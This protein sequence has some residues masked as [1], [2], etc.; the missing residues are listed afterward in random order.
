MKKIYT[1]ACC[2]GLTLTATAQ[3]YGSGMSTGTAEPYVYTN[4]GT[5]VLGI[6]AAEVLSPAQTIPFA[7]NFYGVAVTTYKASDNGYITF[8]AGASTSDPANGSIPNAGGPNDAIYAFWDDL[9]V[10]AG[11][12]SPDEVVSF[13]YGAAP[14]RTHVIQYFSVTPISGTGFMYVA[15]RLHEC[16]DFDIVHNYGNATGMTAT[17]GCEDAT[18]ANGTMVQGPSF[19]YPAL[20]PDGADD[21]VYTFYWD[22]IN[23][24]AAITSSDLTA[25][26]PVGNNTISGQMT[27]NGSQAIT[28]YDLHYTV[29]GGTAVT[30]NVTGVNIAALGGTANYSHSTPLNI[31]SGGESHTVCVW[32]DNLNGNADE[33]SCNDEICTDVFS[34]NNTG[35]TSVAVVLEEF[36]GAWCGW[37]PD[38]G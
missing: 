28:A 17:V 26:I 34:N 10:T 31:A 30:M 29:D 9:G 12:G 13:T 23:Y 8:D 15:V 18:G 4:N 7:W 3:N 27:N 6:P 36:T 21:V 25:F 24:D 2:I 38:G 37:C 5:T 33:R 32:A 19:D 22:G 11:A 35:A 20:Q 14:N 16:G 1:L